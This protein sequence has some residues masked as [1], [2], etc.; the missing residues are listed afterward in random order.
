MATTTTAAT[1]RLELVV[2]AI[3][4]AVPGIR[5]VRLARRDGTPLPGYTPGSHVVVHCDGVANAYSLTG[6]SIAPTRY[7]ISVLRIDEGRGGSRWIHALVPGDRVEVAPPRSAFPPVLA[8]RRHLLVAGGIGVTPI[9]SHLRSAV[10]W[11]REVEVL[12]AHREGSA[13][14]LDEVRSLAGDALHCFTDRA[15]FAAHLT[16]RL[17][18]QPIGTHLYTCGPAGFM[19]AV[20]QTAGRLGWPASRVHLEHFGLAD[21]DGGEPFE[22]VLTASG[23][24]IPVPSGTS[25]LDALEAG[26]LTV[27][28][29]CR[30]GV[31]GECRIPVSAGTPR[32]R[33]LF[34]SDDEKA[35]GSSLMCCVSRAVGDRLEINL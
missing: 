16:A 17:A 14:H 3:D 34:L 30:Q 19:D 11:G 15:V 33:D 32:H 25:L 13:A 2:E 35:A 7:E 23:R 22:A 29:L 24:T 31:C 20:T 8:A 18:D 27:P 6:D 26:G 21:L 1:D 9:L 28:N 12:Y 4:D 10:R 5:S